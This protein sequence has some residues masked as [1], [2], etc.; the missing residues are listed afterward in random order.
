[1]MLQRVEVLTLDSSAY[2]EYACKQAGIRVAYCAEQFENDGSPTATVT[3]GLTG[4]WRAS[5]AASRRAPPRWH[6]S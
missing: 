4:P 6:A 3:R 1:M 5:T 2:Y